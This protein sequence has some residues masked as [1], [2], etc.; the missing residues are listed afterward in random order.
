MKQVQQKNDILFYRITE[1]SMPLSACQRCGKQLI[2]MLKVSKIL[3]KC[4]YNDEDSENT[5]TLR[6]FFIMLFD[7]MDLGDGQFPG[8]SFVEVRKEVIV[9]AIAS[10]HENLASED[11]VCYS[12]GLVCSL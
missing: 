6:Q 10:Y 12:A 1:V 5:R 11:A 7:Q 2:L 4:L 8:Y 9:A 3:C